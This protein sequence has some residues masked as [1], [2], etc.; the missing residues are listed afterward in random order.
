MTMLSVATTVTDMQ[1]ALWKKRLLGAGGAFVV[2]WFALAGRAAEH[3]QPP[4]Q[5]KLTRCP[6][7]DEEKQLIDE[8]DA[9]IRTVP[10][11]SK[12]A[13]VKYP[14]ARIL[15]SENH[16]E[17]AI[18]L[19]WDIVEHH[20]HHEPGPCSMLTVVVGAQNALGGKLYELADLGVGIP[21]LVGDHAPIGVLGRVDADHA[22]VGLVL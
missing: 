4:C 9:F 10:T 18:P 8:Y 15:H 11:P 1:R 17:E 13:K 14:K 21:S 16:F 20:V 6:L 7:S 2:G 22:Q 5:E 12:L 19:F 3:W